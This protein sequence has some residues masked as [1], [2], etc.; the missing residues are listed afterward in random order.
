MAY[1]AVAKA[2]SKEDDL[3][4]EGRIRHHHGDWAE[5][6]FKIIR[7]LRATSIAWKRAPVPQNPRC[8]PRTSFPTNPVCPSPSAPVLPLSPALTPR[9]PPFSSQPC[10]CPT[11]FLP[12]VSS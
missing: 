1:L 5:H 7:K 9:P 3:G 10:L 11:S 12:L 2:F 4:N 8:L 6:G